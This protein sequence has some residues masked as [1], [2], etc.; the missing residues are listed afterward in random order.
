[1]HCFPFPNI[2]TINLNFSRIEWHL[3]HSS[4]PALFLSL[5]F[6]L[7]RHR[8]CSHYI[9]SQKAKERASFLPWLSRMC[10]E[11]TLALQ[12]C[13]S[14]LSCT[15]PLLPESSQPTKGCSL[16]CRARP[17]FLSFPYPQQLPFAQPSS[18]GLRR[19]PL[20][21][22]LTYTPSLLQWPALHFSQT[23]SLFPMLLVPGLLRKNLQAGPGVSSARRCVPVLLPCLLWRDHSSGEGLCWEEH[24]LGCLCSW[25]LTNPANK[26]GTQVS[27]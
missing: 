19:L 14:T 27:K 11:G 16:S 20:T 10:D 23:V 3:T 1:M 6:S 5:S 18:G 2:P 26:T 17:F 15:L 24:L 8:I 21:S 12:P 9:V 7:G 22:C 25:S 4:C 13:L